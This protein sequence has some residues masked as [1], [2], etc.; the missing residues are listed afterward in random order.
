MNITKKSYCNRCR[1]HFEGEVMADI[2]R[3][4]EIINHAT[5]VIHKKMK[6][7][8][9]SVSIATVTGILI[10]IENLTSKEH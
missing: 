8:A 9:V 10:E 2:L 5:L 3:T 7:N 1:Y 4:K 6:K